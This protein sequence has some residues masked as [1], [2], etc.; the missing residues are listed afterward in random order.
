LS[1]EDTCLEKSSALLEVEKSEK[2]AFFQKKKEEDD[3][4]KKKK[5]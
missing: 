4:S 3:S 5:S 1:L 2:N